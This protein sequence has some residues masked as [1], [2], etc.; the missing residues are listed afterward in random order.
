MSVFHSTRARPA[1]SSPP[2]DRHLGLLAGL[3]LLS[4]PV[5]PSQIVSLEITA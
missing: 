1:I 4:P 2:R 5:V 3:I